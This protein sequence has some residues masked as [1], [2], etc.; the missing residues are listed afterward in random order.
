MLCAS[1]ALEPP[2]VPRAREEDRLAAFELEDGRRHRLEEPAVVGDED[3][4]GVERPEHAFEPLERVDVEVVGR[5][6]EQQQIGLRGQRTGERRTRQLAARERREGAV[7]VALAEPDAAHD[8]RR[9]VAPVVAAGVLEAML[10]LGVPAQHR[11]P[12]VAV[13]HGALERSQLALDGREVGRSGQDVLAQ[14]PLARSRGPLVVQRDARALFPRELAAV[15][16]RLP[17]E[18]AEQGRLARAVRPGQGEPVGPLD[19]ER[20]VLEQDRAGKLLAERGCDQDRH[21]LNLSSACR[22]RVS[23]V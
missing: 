12:V 21:R 8:R 3:H 4:R 7:E 22:R 13:G 1:R 5:L 10:S 15:Q 19:L 2:V 23:G 9:A 16:R 17:G 20:D 14:R 6:V 18:G 11:G